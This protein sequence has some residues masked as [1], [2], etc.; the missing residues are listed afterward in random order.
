MKHA[1]AALALAA[2]TI[3]PAAQ[4]QTITPRLYG[5][6][7]AVRDFQK[8]TQFYTLL[9]MQAGPHHNDLEWELKWDSADRGSSIIMIREDQSARFHVVRGA[10]T[11]IISTPDVYAALARLRGAGFAVPGEPRVMGMGSNIMIQ[12]PDGDWIELAGPA[13]AAKAP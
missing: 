9:G 3:V 10:G 13:P 7:L 12:D 5:V 11:L 4:A 8:T 2:A 6:K 1:I